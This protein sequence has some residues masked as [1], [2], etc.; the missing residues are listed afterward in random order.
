MPLVKRRP[1]AALDILDIW[2]RIAEEDVTAADR[3]VDQLDTALNRLATQPMMG[4]SRE[5]LADNL[6]S[7][8]FR[9]YVIFYLPIEDGIDVVRV[10]HGAR[11]IDAMFGEGP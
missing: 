5:E 1:L 8:P 6:R 11:D 3:W 4:R 10:L 7:L 9:R 2:D